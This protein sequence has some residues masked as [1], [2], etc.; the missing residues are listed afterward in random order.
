[1]NIT[2]QGG[3]VGVPDARRGETMKVLIVVNPAFSGVE[4]GN[5]PGA[6]PADEQLNLR[7]PV[8]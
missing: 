5:S 1:L 3:V 6:A 8:D 4:I 7:P 2:V